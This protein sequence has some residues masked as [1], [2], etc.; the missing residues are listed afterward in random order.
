MKFYYLNAELDG[1]PYVSTLKEAKVLARETAKS[2]HHDIE[3][4]QV[5]IPTDRANILRLANTAGGTHIV[6]REA[7]YTAKARLK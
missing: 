4:T 2:S 7:V 1:S 3:V 5:D 6:L